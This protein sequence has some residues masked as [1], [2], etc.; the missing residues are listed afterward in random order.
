MRQAQRALVRLLGEA[1]RQERGRLQHDSTNRM[2]SR[3]SELELEPV[4][5]SAPRSEH[6]RRLTTFVWT[7]EVL[8]RQW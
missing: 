1:N 3:G 5:P 7:G 2:T 4:C 8:S 6:P